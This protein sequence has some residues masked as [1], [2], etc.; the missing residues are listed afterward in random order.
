MSKGRWT[1]DDEGKILRELA[2]LR[3]DMQGLGEQWD[4]RHR[5]LANDVLEIRTLAARAVE[6]ANEAKRIADGSRH[7]TAQMQ[8]SVM[9]HT[10]GLA[11]RQVALEAETAKQTGQLTALL[12]A[13]TDRKTREDEREKQ[14]E[15]RWKWIQR[16]WPI[17]TAVVAIAGYVIGHWRP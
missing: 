4:T 5:T 11:A 2:G 14:D 8:A 15:R 16:A 17:A 7:D 6:T 9:E 10:K 13:E 1:V 3:R 12:A